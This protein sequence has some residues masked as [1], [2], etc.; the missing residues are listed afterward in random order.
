MVSFSLLLI[1]VVVAAFATGSGRLVTDSGTGG[2]G[3]A[4]S[5]AIFKT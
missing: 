2:V 3:A 5:L 4:V 1:G